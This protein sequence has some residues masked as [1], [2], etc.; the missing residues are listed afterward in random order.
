[1][2]FHIYGPFRKY[3]FHMLSNFLFLLIKKKNCL[4]FPGC[5]HF[6]YF[7]ASHI[8][9]GHESYMVSPVIAAHP[10]TKYCLSFYL[11]MYSP[12]ATEMGAL[13]VHTWQ[14]NDVSSVWHHAGVMTYNMSHWRLINV[15]LTVLSNTPFAVRHFLLF[16]GHPKGPKSPV[17]I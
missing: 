15:D 17:L 16:F 8:A 1:M 14:G 10:Q 2:L 6:V 9:K 3:I 5:G 7:E 12:I 11:S 4:S 13:S